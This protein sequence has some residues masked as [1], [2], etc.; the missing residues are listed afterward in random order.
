MTP[1]APQQNP[2]RQRHDLSGF[3]QFCFDPR[4]AGVARGFPSG[5]ARGGAE[6][7]RPVAV[8]ASYNEQF[9]DGRDYLGPVWYEREF[10]VPWGWEGRR[11]LVRFGSVNYHASVWLN[12]ERL[13]EHEG[14]HLPFVLDA[15]RAVRSEKNRLVVRAEGE[16]RPDRVPPGNV[17]R[18][19]NDAFANGQFP[20]GSFDFF[21]YA[22]IQR[23]VV[24]FTVPDEPILDVTLT[25]TLAA[26][27][28]R[29]GVLVEARADGARLRATL[30]G[31]GFETVAEAALGDERTRLE[32]DVPKARLWAP[33]EPNLYELRV[34]LVRNDTVV[35]R[36]TLPVGLRTVAVDASR[37]LVNG[38][39]VYLRGFGR[40]E[41]FPIVGRGLAPPVVIKDYALLRWIG[42]NSFRTTHYPYSDEMLDLADRLG[43]LVIA[44][45]PAVG[46]FFQSAGL[47]R[48]L[49]L[50]RAMTRE[51]VLRDKNHPSVVAW[52]LANE[53]H[54]RRPEAR[55]FFAEL[56]ALARELDPTR[57][58]TLVSY[59][60]KDET[61]FELCDFLCV[62][63]YNGWYSESGRIA[64]GMKLLSADLDAIHARYG[65][66]I[67]LSE[68]GADAVPGMHAEPS[69]MFTEEYQAEMISSVVA[70]LREKPYVLGEHV[71][72]LCDFKTGQAIHRV[73]G[74]NYKGVFTRDRRPKQAARTLRAL[75]TK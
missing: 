41:D 21:P 8:P 15:T 55:A 46:L 13:G 28:A 30:E 70:L 12:G 19:P 2:F 10:D 44:E 67:L 37:L 14:G 17:P 24:V 75:W 66:P 54:S 39:P 16:L 1:L 33:G 65:K 74:I 69:E 59:V 51:L 26:D 23:P 63:R 73:G 7:V 71:W 48:R 56:I 5:L 3:W 58:V 52:S 9:E 68:F 45:T 22:G 6:G 42:A 29:L 57:L 61:S 25:T 36:V 64:D 72:N 38:R 49:S 47:E 20:D 40:H 11:V 18:N 60:G 62:N 50:C 34:E 4:D 32:L 43:F 27:T 31:F 35:D 53:P